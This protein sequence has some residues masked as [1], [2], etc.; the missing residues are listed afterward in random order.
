MSV[1]LTTFEP[2]KRFADQ[3]KHMRVEVDPDKLEYEYAR[4]SW[5]G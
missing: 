5:S 2:S 3:Q 1:P 4:A